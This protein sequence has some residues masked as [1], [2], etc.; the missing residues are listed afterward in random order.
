MSQSRQVMEISVIV[1]VFREQAGI[2]AFV[3]HLVDI[4]PADRYEIIVVDGSPDEETRK[5][6]DVPGIS[7]LASDKGRARQMNAGAGQATAQVL[8]FVHADT[9]LP[10]NSAQ[11]IPSA[12]KDENIVGGS[13]SL[14]IASKRPFLKLV[15]QVA[16]LR[17]RWTRV[18]YGDQ[19]IFVRRDYFHKIGGFKDIP[20]MEDLEFMTRIKKSGG[21][22]EI[23]PERVKT[24]ARRWEREGSLYCTLR[25]WLIRIMYHFGVSADRISSFY[26]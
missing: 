7:T 14:G 9:R 12:L 20:I 13:F 23:L 22:I 18:P 19:G 17:S 11:L 25:N 15:E 8:L 2:N 24:S 6:L 1:P 21:K 26:R 16:N 10:A 3:R 5:A 4:F